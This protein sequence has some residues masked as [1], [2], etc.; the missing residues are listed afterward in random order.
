MF[1]EGPVSELP[2]RL[3]SDSTG[4]LVHGELD[5]VVVGDRPREGVVVQAVLWRFLR[6]HAVRSGPGA[7]C[8]RDRGSGSK[9]KALM[10]SDE[11]PPLRK[12]WGREEGEEA[13][14]VSTR[15]PP[16]AAR[17]R[18]ADELRRVSMAEDL[19]VEVVVAEGQHAELGE[20]REVARGT[21][22]VKRFFS[23]LSV[24]SGRALRVRGIET[25]V[26]SFPKNSSSS[27][28][29]REDV[30][31]QGPVR[32]LFSIWMTRGFAGPTP[33]EV[34]GGRS[35]GD[36]VRHVAVDVADDARDSQ[37][38]LVAD[39]VEALGVM[40]ST[41]RKGLRRGPPRR[42]LGTSVVAWATHDQFA[43]ARTGPDGRP[44]LP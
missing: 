41:S 18:K 10:N 20:V 33:R 16:Q 21:G 29:A 11:T 27:R 17:H 34:R 31:G 9:G 38:V 5:E 26:S 28:L 35:R 4:A 30:G 37:A 24:V 39:V 2:T 1:G 44:E 15:E 3:S 19:A 7:R 25:P 6:Q 13:Q 43:G 42:H 36:E 8:A 23:R 12:L 22:P 14:P 40:S 32:R